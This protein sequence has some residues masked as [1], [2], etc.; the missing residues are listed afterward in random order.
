MQG[1]VG[2][3]TAIGALEDDCLKLITQ[4]S[5]LTSLLD[6]LTKRTKKQSLV[7]QHLIKYRLFLSLS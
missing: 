6:N 2:C 4:A 3:G 7:A 5:V 1:S